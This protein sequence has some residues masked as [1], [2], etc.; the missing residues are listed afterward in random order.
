MGIAPE[1]LAFR[2]MQTLADKLEA[3]GPAPQFTPEGY[4]PYFEPSEDY[5]EC[6]SRLRK[7]R[8]L[9]PAQFAQLPDA[10]GVAVELDDPPDTLDD[11]I[12]IGAALA[13]HEAEAA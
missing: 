6:A 12:A 5:L 13:R 1:E 11:L 7:L 3:I 9:Y 10:R 2:E 4:G 8:G